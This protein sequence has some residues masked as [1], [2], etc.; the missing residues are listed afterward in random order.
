M[1]R[2]SC[3][4]YPKRTVP[5][6]YLCD[7]PVAISLSYKNE[8]FH[9]EGLAGDIFL[10]AN[11]HNTTNQLL[12]HLKQRQHACQ[13]DE[14]PSKVEN[15]ICDLVDKQ[16]MKLC[17]KPSS[18]PYI[19]SERFPVPRCVADLLPD[20][21]N[22]L[23]KVLID[24]FF[25]V[26]CIQQFRFLID[27]FGFSITQVRRRIDRADILFQC[28]RIALKFGWSRGY[29]T[30]G[31]IGVLFDEIPELRTSIPIEQVLSSFGYERSADRYP[32]HNKYGKSISLMRKVPVGVDEAIDKEFY[33]DL[34]VVGNLMQKHIK[35][36]LK[37]V[38]NKV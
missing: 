19:V 34:S 8:L 23:R 33:H 3:D 4:C 38:A 5:F 24:A 9:L 16:L 32:A 22:S 31:C 27:D 37:C 14:L 13:T 6:N 7:V 21:K 20:D 1:M 10:A 26:P 28:G 17:D 30:H 12:E 15:I 29:L 25:F 35:E 2:L 36:I 11:G 18:L